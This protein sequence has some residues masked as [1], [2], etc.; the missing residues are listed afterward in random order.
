MWTTTSTTELLVV[1]VDVVEV[2]LLDVV[3]SPRS[4]RW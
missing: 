3:V 2:V 4:R 1:L